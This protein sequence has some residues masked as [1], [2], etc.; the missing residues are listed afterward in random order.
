MLPD[1]YKIL[2]VPEDASQEVIKKQ[3]KKLAQ[4]YHPDKL[5]K[6]SDVLREL[7]VEKFID[8]TEAYKILSDPIRRSEHDR[9]RKE[10][11]DI[12]EIETTLQSIKEFLN[13]GNL[14]EAVELAH[15]LHERFPDNYDLR[16]NYAELLYELA[17]ELEIKGREEEART[18][19]E[20]VISIAT[21]EYIRH[22]AEE[23]LKQ[24]TARY[25]VSEEKVEVH[26]KKGI[27]LRKSV[28]IGMLI[29]IG[30]VLINNLIKN[31]PNSND[32]IRKVDFRNYTYPLKQYHA[33]V[34]ES[35]NVSVSNGRFVFS[36]HKIYGPNGFE[37]VSIY[38]EDLTGDR[39]EEA[40]VNMAI[41]NLEGGT[42]SNNA[43]I[44]SYI[45]TVR[46]NRTVLLT[47]LDTAYVGAGVQTD[48]SNYYQDDTWLLHAGVIG[49]ENGMLKITA[50]AGKAMCCPEY[51]VSMTFRWN[52]QRFELTR[53]PMRTKWEHDNSNK[54]RTST[55]S[56]ITYHDTM[57]FVNKYISILNRGRINEIVAL[58][59]DSVDYFEEGF[60]SKDTIRQDKLKYYQRWPEVDHKL[61]SDITVH[62]SGDKNMILVEFITSFNVNNPKKRASITGRAENIIEVRRVDGKLKIKA[63]KQR[64]LD[65]TKHNY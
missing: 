54:I 18:Y 19:L 17:K 11:A 24:L 27:G 37:V 62:N 45:Y 43:R 46:D 7:A 40:I 44:Y 50:I 47:F 59:D 14:P 32:Q 31:S 38:Y 8:I 58:Y 15:K 33:K 21:D 4:Y 41:G 29:I 1:Y 52:G 20:T 53:E 5:Q 6:L 63:E 9:K 51:D 42:F 56:E 22:D 48:Y 36:N 49:V 30:F 64:I 57:N 2:G 61:D 60:V 55:E 35:D 10:A 3:Y 34:Y 26:E 28:F 65:R 12:R 23:A 13:R 39:I 16:N 25:N